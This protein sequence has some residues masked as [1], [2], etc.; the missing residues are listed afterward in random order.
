MLTFEVEEV[1]FS[2]A[3][4]LALADD[5][6]R[7]DLLSELGLTLLDRSEEEITDRAGGVPVKASTG[8][9]AGEH[10]QV[11]SS[12]VVSAVHD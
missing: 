5:D 11:L 7:H 2:S 4:G 8:H 10:V 1:A 12:S 3:D 9:G 6:S